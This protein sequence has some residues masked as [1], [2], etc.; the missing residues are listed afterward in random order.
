MRKAARR[1]NG[2][3]LFEVVLTFDPREK[4]PYK[5]TVDVPALPGC[6]SEGR[7][8]EEALENIREAIAL[9]LAVRTERP[10]KHTELVEVTV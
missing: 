8:R 3:R 9:I 5:Y 10:R 6:F 2:T 7:T 1:S 4:G